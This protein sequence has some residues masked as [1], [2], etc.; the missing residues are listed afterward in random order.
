MILRIASHV[1]M[2]KTMLSSIHVKSSRAHYSALYVFALAPVPHM[3]LF[4]VLIAGP[5]Q[6]SVNNGCYGATRSLQRMNRAYVVYVRN[7]GSGVGVATTADD[8]LTQHN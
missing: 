6:R 3:I 8:L 4:G 7:V 2:E 5:P 1:S